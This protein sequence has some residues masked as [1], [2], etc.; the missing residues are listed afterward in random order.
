M[1]DF[2]LQNVG[3]VFLA[4]VAIA[5]GFFLLIRQLMLWYWKVDE[6]LDRLASI[7]ES[8]KQLPAVQR[9]LGAAPGRRN[10]AA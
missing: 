10:N 1:D 3:L 7:D 8:L 2:I 4:F 9:N 6:I 5:F